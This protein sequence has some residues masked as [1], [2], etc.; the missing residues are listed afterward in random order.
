MFLLSMFAPPPVWMGE[1]GNRLILMSD[2]DGKVLKIIF[3]NSTTGSIEEGLFI[4]LFS[5]LCHSSKSG[6]SFSQKR[7]NLSSNRKKIFKN[8]KISTRYFLFQGIPG[9]FFEKEVAP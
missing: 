3:S 5:S 1:E 6:V 2:S 8:Y 7:L 4:L 9:V